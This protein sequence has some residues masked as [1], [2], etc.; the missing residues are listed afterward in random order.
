[1]TT[2]IENT[3]NTF[4]DTRTTEDLV[5][6]LTALHPDDFT[7]KA[8]ARSYLED[9][10]FKAQKPVTKKQQLEEWFLSQPD[11]LEVTSK[12][13]KEQC[14]LLDMKGSSGT[15]YASAYKIAQELATKIK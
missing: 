15:F 9:K 10:G 8:E 14:R 1:M 12:Q 2:T 13:I 5:V 4:K 6:L 7:T 3:I 11:P